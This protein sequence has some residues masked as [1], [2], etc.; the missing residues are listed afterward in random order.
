MNDT[1]FRL[2]GK[3]ILITG[4]SSGFGAHFA[5]VLSSAGAEVVLVARRLEKLEE[6]QKNVQAIG[7]PATVLTMDVSD[8][9]SVSQGFD[10]IGKVDVVINNAGINVTGTTDTLSEESWDQ[11]IDTNLKGAWMVAKY[12]IQIWKADHQPGNIINIGS[13]VG[14][15]MSNQLPAYIA[16]KAAILG[17]TQSIALDYARYNIR[18]NALC[19]G[20]ME[21]DLNRDYMQTPAGEKQVKRIPFRR[22]E[23]RS[24]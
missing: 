17:L 4:A 15:R 19:P 8:S 18:C 2:D 6:T 20:Y 21:T 16:S 14:M 12:A 24:G 11:A 10:E 1:L 22:F 5:E 9:K 13:I 23:K 7:G 3:R